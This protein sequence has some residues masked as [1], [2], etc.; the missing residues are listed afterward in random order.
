MILS[1]RNFIRLYL[2]GLFG[3]FSSFTILGKSLSVFVFP[4]LYL[5]SIAF[6]LK[7]GITKSKINFIQ[8]SICILTGI[9]ISSI[10]SYSPV[11]SL[12]GILIIFF[13]II[14][15]YNIHKRFSEPEIFKLLYSSL[16]ILVI[17]G[18]IV[19]IINPQLAIYYDPLNRLNVIGLPNYK[20]LY[21][22]KIQAGI[23]SIIGVILSSN[24]YSETKLKSHLFW[25]FIFI[26]HVLLCGSSL[27]LVCLFL[28]IIIPKAFIYIRKTFGTYS[29]GFFGII[30]CFLIYTIIISDEYKTILIFLG[31]S[32]NLT[33]RTSIWDYAFDYFNSNILFGGGY[34][35]FFADVKNSPANELWSKMEYYNAPSF[36]NGFIQL[37]AEAGFVGSFSFFILL[38]ITFRKCI[39]GKNP[40]FLSLILLLILTNLGASLFIFPNSFF[41]VILLYIFFVN[42][43]LFNVKDHNK[44]FT[45]GYPFNS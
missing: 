12:L 45:L 2:I 14:F 23:F 42:T 37:F 7:S 22:H 28:I 25:C 40:I 15:A 6:F 9:T 11:S 21:P 26:V 41:I 30:F 33:G 18:V 32:E 20:G 4:I 24:F 36:H 35:V 17:L 38:I 29:L 27:A 43:N 3:V 44:E 34:N 1:E 8:L 19:Y 31:R 10:L 16:K 5:I 13:N 39:K